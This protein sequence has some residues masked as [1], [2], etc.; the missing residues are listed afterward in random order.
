MLTAVGN[1]TNSKVNVIAY[2]MG[3]P[4]ARKVCLYSLTLFKIMEKYS[5]QIHKMASLN[6]TFQLKFYGHTVFL[7]NIRWQMRRYT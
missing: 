1:F 6:T 7:G 5:K 3:S 2:A 4:V